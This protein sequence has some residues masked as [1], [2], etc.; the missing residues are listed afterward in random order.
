MTSYVLVRRLAER[1]STESHIVVRCQQRHKK[2]KQKK[3]T[4]VS[5][6]F[7]LPRYEMH[8]S[9]VLDR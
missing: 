5:R 3:S 8:S 9:N 6:D 1:Y 7:A 2:T 4:K